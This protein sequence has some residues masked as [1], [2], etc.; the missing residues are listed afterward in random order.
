M[1]LSRCL[2]PALLALAPLLAAG[3]YDPPVSYYNSAA[4]LQGTALDS[5]LNNITDGHTSISYGD[6]DEVMHVIDENPDMPGF[7]FVLYSNQSMSFGSFGS[8]GA[9]IW[10]REHTF[11]QSYGASDGHARSDLHHLFPCNANV[12]SSRGN[13][14]FDETSGSGSS[15]YLAPDSS[16]DFDSWEPRDE[17]KGRV[18]RAILYM[19]CRY[20]GT[21]SGTPDLELREN[22]SSGA[23]HMA[24]LST[25]LDWNRAYPPDERERRRNHWIYTGVNT[26]KGFRGQYNRNPFVDFPE[27]GD[28]IHLAGI[29]ITRGTWRWEHFSPA[30][31]L[32]ETVSDDDSNPDRDAYS[33]LLELAFNLDPWEPDGAACTLMWS[34]SA[35]TFTYP[36]LKDYALSGLTYTV[37]WTLDPSDPGS[38]EPFVPQGDEEDVDTAGLMQEVSVDLS[39]VD[40]DERLFVR[41]RVTRAE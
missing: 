28:A 33:N 5:A 20:D 39:R 19:D 32:D 6:T 3:P 25:L 35:V 27:L 37:E 11:P 23:H 17:D 4:G 13:K 38:W 1:K 29:A 41:L 30:Q 40:P 7:V 16:Y 9:T 18:A 31:L 2:A 10:N 21:D 22:A 34:P 15:Y 26:S 14:Y 36:R 8:G 24:R 12:N